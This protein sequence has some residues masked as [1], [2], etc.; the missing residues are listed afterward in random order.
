M[1]PGFKTGKKIKTQSPEL[2]RN[3]K[4]YSHS[5]ITVEIQKINVPRRTGKTE[6]TK[7][8]TINKGREHTSISS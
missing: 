1:R 2:P 6:K 5:L 8:E 3:F 7:E 4:K